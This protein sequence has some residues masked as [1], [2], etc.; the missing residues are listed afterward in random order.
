MT[1]NAVTTP[2]NN[3]K[4]TFTGTSTDTSDAVTVNVYR[5]NSASGTLVQT[6]PATW[7][8]S[9]FSV[10]ASPALIDGTY[11][12]VATQ[13]DKAGNTGSSSPQTFVIDTM[14]T[15]TT[16]TASPSAV[17]AGGSVM[18]SVGVIAGNLTPVNEGMVTF[19][20]VDPTTGATVA[21]DN[22]VLVQ[23]GTAID[24]NF[25][26]P[27]ATA[28]NT[29]N[30]VAQFTDTGGSFSA[31]FTFASRALTVNTRVPVSPPPAPPPSTDPVGALSLFAYGY[32]PY[33]QLDIF[34]VDQAGKVYAFP[35]DN[36]F[37]GHGAIEFI[38]NQVWFPPT[39]WAQDGNIAG[40][41][42][43]A[44]AMEILNASNLF[45]YDALFAAAYAELTGAP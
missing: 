31:T 37:G 40:F 5:G 39:L 21:S 16:P 36:L 25:T 45:V 20:L 7:Q 3:S 44:F 28:A 1:L 30:L 15:L 14:P 9:T 12:V 43:G 26:I 18:M 10:Q 33:A 27:A 41:L 22:G 6:L 24:P 4:P 8:G 23:N 17:L 13:T 32:G 34:E 11:T 19:L 29:Y 35:L 2:S 42:D 38:S